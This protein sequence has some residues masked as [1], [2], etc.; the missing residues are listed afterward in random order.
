MRV[1]IIKNKGATIWQNMYFDKEIT[2]SDGNK[3]NAGKLFFR[4]KDAEAYLKALEHN[5]FY[6]VVGATV[7]KSYTDNR[8]RS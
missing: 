7:D 6:E 4:K 1:F 2:F 5:E 8:K 3:I